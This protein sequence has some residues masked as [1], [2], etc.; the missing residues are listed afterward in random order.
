MNFKIAIVKSKM[1]D[2][3]NKGTKALGSMVLD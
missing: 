2:S 1:R 3:G